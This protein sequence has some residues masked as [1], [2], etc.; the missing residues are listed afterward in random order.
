MPKV[1]QHHAL[2]RQWEVLRQLPNRAPGITA[3][4]LL[5]R[6]ESAG[7]RYACN[8]LHYHHRANTVMAPIHDRMP[9]I[10][11]PDQYDAWLDPSN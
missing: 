7:R 5:G 11:Q 4:E 8:D 6:L 1:A 9:V 3:R 10:L 2:A